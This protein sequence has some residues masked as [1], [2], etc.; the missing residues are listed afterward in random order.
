MDYM[1]HGA[2]WLWNR[3]LILLHAPSDLAT[4]LAY[5]VI[6]I[7]VIYVYRAGQLRGLAAAYPQLWRLGAAFV[8]FCG[9]SHLGNFLEVWW[10]GPIYVITGANKIVMAVVSMWFAYVLFRARKDL[11]FFGKG[12]EAVA[13]RLKAAADEE[14][15]R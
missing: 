4:F 10:G 3:L 8:F 6:P 15:R 5:A 13:R 11:V 14:S 9:L 7:T 12:L 2:C 1:P